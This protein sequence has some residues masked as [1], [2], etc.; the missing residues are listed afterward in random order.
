MC[1]GFKNNDIAFGCGRTPTSNERQSDNDKS[2]PGAL[3]AGAFLS[4]WYWILP[5][6]PS[7]P[8]FSDFL[9]AMDGYGRT[10]LK[11]HQTICP[12]LRAD[13]EG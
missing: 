7:E 3:N 2:S 4:Q 1:H 9:N 13:W 10:W 5:Y 8:L 6:D 11:V 12:T